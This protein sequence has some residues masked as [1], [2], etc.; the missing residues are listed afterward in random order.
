[1]ACRFSFLHSLSLSL[2]LS[3]LFL[4]LP[5]HPF[6][7]PRLFLPPLSFPSLFFLPISFSPPLSSSLP[8]LPLTIQ[9]FLVSMMN[10]GDSDSD[11]YQLLKQI[12][13]QPSDFHSGR[14]KHISLPQCTNKDART[15][16]E[17]ALHGVFSE[18][19]PKNF[20]VGGG[21][22]GGEVRKG[23][24]AWSVKSTSF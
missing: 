19:H 6:P 2:S 10:L 5:L 17:T 16:F 1:M 3:P 15:S 11:L 20:L 7:L 12:D 23:K 21:R 9:S 4:C 14:L 13:Y 18:F 24:E 8:F 22:A